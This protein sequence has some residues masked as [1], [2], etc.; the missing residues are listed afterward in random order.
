M[1][2]QITKMFSAQKAKK[3]TQIPLSGTCGHRILSIAKMAWPPI[4][5]WIPNH[6]QAT[7]A[8]KTAGTLA[9]R[10]PNDART[11]TGN[12]IPYFAPACALSSIG[13]STIRLPS[14]MVA[15]GLP[16]AHSSGDQAGCEHIGRDANAHRDPQRSVVV[17]GPR[18]PRRWDRREVFVVERGVVSYCHAPPRAARFRND[19]RPVRPR[20]WPLSTIFSPRENT[21]RALPLTLKPSNIE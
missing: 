11:R 4:Q 16:P 20:N 17:D 3:H 5:V 1:P 19:P 7:S 15:D 18:A 12:G 6:P 2:F 14:R 8:R 9:P 10:T 13:T 21:V